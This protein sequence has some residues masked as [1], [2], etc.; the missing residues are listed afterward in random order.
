ME[1]TIVRHDDAE[2]AWSCSG[3][4]LAH[5]SARCRTV[6]LLTASHF[7]GVVHGFDVPRGM[8]VCAAQTWR[9]GMSWTAPPRS[10]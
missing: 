3:I 1:V 2:E 5:V 8:K 4:R 7:I 6:Q 9:L 10:S